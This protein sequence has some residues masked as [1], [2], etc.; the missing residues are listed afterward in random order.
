[1][2]LRRLGNSGL[3]VSSLCLGAMMFGDRTDA[4][5][6]SRIVG[7][8]RDAGVNFIDT[9][10][11]Y[12]K[13][14]SE[15]ITGKLIAKDRDSWVLATKVN[16]VMGPGPNERG[17]SRKWI[18][19]ELDASLRRL[20]TDYVDIYYMHRDDLTTPFE[21]SIGAMAD[22]IRAGK[23]RYWAFSNFLAWKIGFLVAT[24]ERIGA[25]R[26]IAAQPC[27]NA[28]T[29]LAE[30]DY[31]PAC[32]HYGIGVVPYSPLARGVLTAKY[33]PG[34]NPAKGT[35][36][37]RNDPR[38]MQ[39]EWREPSLV[40]AQKIAKRAAKRGMS[41]ADFAMAWVLRNPLISSVIAGPRTAEQWQ[42]YIDALGHTLDADDEAFIDKLVPPGCASDPT[43]RDPQDSVEG[44]PV[45]ATKAH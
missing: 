27:Y 25:P 20:G 30:A 11:A 8:A 31:L 43:Y 18:M 12:T 40:I 41:A 36:A 14:E 7:M 33:T 28:V 13:G 44:R 1:M 19:Q 2:E 3:K 42:A 5:E 29:R 24:A 37:G 23:V 15:R 22:L 45:G 38:L 32:A 10:D 34:Q 21:E 9:A 39:T 35:R 26:P 4:R 16:G 17:L 6:A